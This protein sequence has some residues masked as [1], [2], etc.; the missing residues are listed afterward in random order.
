VN[1]YWQ[2]IVFDWD[3]TV[4]DSTGAIVRAA[5]RAIDDVGLP[6]PPPQRIR[7]IIGLGLR[8]SWESLFPGHGVDGYEE[9]VAKYRD[10]FV[11]GERHAIK[12][13]P[14]VE[15]LIADLHGVGVRL[16]VATGKSRRGLDR[17]LSETGLGR[18]F[19]CS[20]TAD[21]ARSK[22]HPEMLLRI[23]DQ[24]GIRA[25]R[26]L[27]VG[28]TDFDLQMARQAGVA[29]IAVA[30]GAHERGRLEAVSPLACL[31]SLVDLARWLENFEPETYQGLR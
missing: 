20:V 11:N 9:F 30:W 28:D 17:D 10:H 4:M 7:E 3:G 1:S 27:M 13:Y 16:A 12:T 15:R 22:P 23:L 24:T 6:R 29:A 19:E 8:E 5:E 31:N 18:Y 2:L 21:E 14:G 26:A 25:D